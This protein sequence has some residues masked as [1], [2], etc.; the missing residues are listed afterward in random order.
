MIYEGF[1]R[2]IL[3]SFDYLYDKNKEKFLVPKNEKQVFSVLGVDY[4]EPESRK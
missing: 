4:K 1:K 2:N 3:F